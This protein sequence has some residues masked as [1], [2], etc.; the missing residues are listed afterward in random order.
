MQ[1]GY[2][3]PRPHSIANCVAGARLGLLALGLALMA[4]AGEPEW[5]A[6]PGYG[7]FRYFPQRGFGSLEVMLSSNRPWL[8]AW[9][10][11]DCAS[12]GKYV[13]FGPR[14]NLALG[15]HWEVALSAGPGWYSDNQRLNLGS[16]LEFRSSLYLF[17]TLGGGRRIGLA[18]SHYSNGGLAYHNPG[19]E[20]VRILYGATLGGTAR[21]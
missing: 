3:I 5:M 13:G 16:K 1:R 21:R 14:L 7:P 11:L 20:T 9:A 2:R 18:V 8:A 6:G 19:A 15:S 12:E 17:R 10:S 4:R